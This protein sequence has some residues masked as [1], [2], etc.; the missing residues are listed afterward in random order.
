MTSTPASTIAFIAAMLPS[1]VGNPAGMQP[2][3]TARPS[4]RAFSN[5]TADRSSQD[6]E[7][8]AGGVHVLV[9]AAGQV[10][11]DDRLAAQLRGER[12]D[13]PAA[14]P[15][16]ACALSIAGMIPSVRQSS[17]NAAIASASVT[18]S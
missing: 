6:P 11:H 3:S 15:A 5:A 10:D 8:G 7:V 9:A 18:G 4:A 1:T 13:R 2:T 17:W 12:R 16:S 14:A